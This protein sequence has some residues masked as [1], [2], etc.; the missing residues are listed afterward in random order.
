MGKP[1]EFWKYAFVGG[2]GAEFP[3]QEILFKKLVDKSMETFQ[4]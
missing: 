3:K 2:S 4:I 1:R